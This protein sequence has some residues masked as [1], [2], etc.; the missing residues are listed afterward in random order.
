[1]NCKWDG[2]KGSPRIWEVW[3]DVNAE[4][5]RA[6]E[7]HPG[8]KA[9]SP[10][11]DPFATARG[12][13]KRVVERTFGAQDDGTFTVP[14]TPGPSL[15]ADELGW[16]LRKSVEVE[17]LKQRLGVDAGSA[18]TPWADAIRQ[19]TQLNLQLYWELCEW[20]RERFP[21]MT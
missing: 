1:V 8:Y 12:G 5:T 6:G 11:A 15:P 21:G 13:I 2:K 4:K 10:A 16:K 18:S 19:R 3:L 9:T 17:Q 20:A 14:V 7:E